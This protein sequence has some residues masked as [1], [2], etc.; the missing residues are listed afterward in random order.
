MP[1]SWNTRAGQ[2]MRSR[3]L[4]WLTE[5]ETKTEDMWL[6]WEVQ[7]HQQ[8]SGDGSQWEVNIK[9]TTTVS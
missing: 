3:S 8:G 1:V 4:G 5:P 6:I 7:G 2:E 9:P